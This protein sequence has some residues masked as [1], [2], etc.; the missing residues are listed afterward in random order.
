MHV[1]CYILL[2]SAKITSTFPEKCLCLRK[3]MRQIAY[4]NLKTNSIN[5][6]ISFSILAHLASKE[7]TQFINLSSTLPG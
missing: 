3:Y 7:L 4:L 5:Y 2:V 6:K 1:S